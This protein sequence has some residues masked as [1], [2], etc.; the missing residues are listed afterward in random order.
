[1]SFNIMMF[2]CIN[3]ICVHAEVLPISQN[4]TLYRDRIAQMKLK[5]KVL[6][7]RDFYALK[8]KLLCKYHKKQM[9]TC[10]FK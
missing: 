6:K 4:W 5:L 2:Y 9:D 10:T 8:R 1:M 3:I 7:I